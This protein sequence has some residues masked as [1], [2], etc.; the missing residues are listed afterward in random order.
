MSMLNKLAALP[1]PPIANA[2]SKEV[3]KQLTKEISEPDG[4]GGGLRRYIKFGTEW[5]WF[6][7][8]MGNAGCCC[9][10]VRVQL[11]EEAVLWR[12]WG[13]DFEVERP[14]RCFLLEWWWW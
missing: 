13:A 7:R 3:E 14:F 10:A 11:L 2:S 4:E 8:P 6:E 5:W 1:P 9:W 12:E